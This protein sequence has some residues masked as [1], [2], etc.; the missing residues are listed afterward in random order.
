MKATLKLNKK[1]RTFYFQGK[2]GWIT[3]GYTACLSVTQSKILCLNS[4]IPRSLCYAIMSHGQCVVSAA[5][6]SLSPQNCLCLVFA[7]DNAT[8]HGCLILVSTSDQ[9][10]YEVD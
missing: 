7:R 6:P 1:Q 5:T 9:K 2:T 4:G 10:M 3:T 8:K